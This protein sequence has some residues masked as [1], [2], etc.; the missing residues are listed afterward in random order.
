MKLYVTYSN[1]RFS[2][3][4]RYVFEHFA[5]ITGFTHIVFLSYDEVVEMAE[6]ID[7]LVSYGKEAPPYSGAHIHISEAELFTND[8]LKPRSLPKAPLPK[9]GN[10]PVLFGERPED[11]DWIRKG[12]TQVTSY[13]DIVAGTFFLLTR[14]EEL[15]VTER[16]KFGRFPVELSLLSNTD[17][18]DRPLADEY[19]DLFLSWIVQLNPNFQPKNPLGDHPLS[20]YITHDVD[21]PWKY[22]WKNLPRLKQALGCGLSSLLGRKRDPFWTFPEFLALEKEYG[23]SAD[24]FFMS[25]GSHALDRGYTIEHPSILRL[26]E[27]LREGGARIGIHFSLSAHFSLALSG[28]GEEFARELTHFIA[29]THKTAVGSRQHYL[30][31]RIPATWR[32]LE[33]LGIPFD[34][35]LGFAE[36]PGFRCGTC[37][38]FRCFDAKKGRSL[39]VHEIPLIAMDSTFIYYLKYS[40]DQAFSKM[41]RLFKTVKR[42]RGVFCLLWHNNSL[43]EQ[44]YPGWGEMYRRFLREAM[45]ANPLVEN[46]L[47]YYH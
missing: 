26:I 44:D 6:V 19:I 45:E 21:T 42:H 40:P 1:E 4:I 13:I 32:R 37:R 30:A 3:H 35:S 46:P 23:I 31:V 8:Y 33:A 5:K 34:T 24:Y 29:V 41:T 22:T 2:A 43:S 12:P 15:I 36:K 27:S 38:P 11:G 16:D 47:H 17:L 28:E 14:Y 18:L 39:K 9:W 10:L 25:G 7:L 20:L